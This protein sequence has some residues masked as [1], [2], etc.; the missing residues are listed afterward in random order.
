MEIVRTNRYLKDLKRLNATKT[1]VDALEA[2]IAQHPLSGDVIPG[3]RGIRKIRFA[4]DGRG[5]RGG[6]RAIY[7]LRVSEEL[8]IMLNAYAKSEQDEL[9]GDQKKLAL[10]VLKEFH[11]D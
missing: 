2:M 3:L 4:F 6:G 9:T 5:K 1:E 8:V 11:H 7:F 10:A